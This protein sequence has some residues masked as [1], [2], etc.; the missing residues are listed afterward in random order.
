MKACSIV[1]CICRRGWAADSLDELLNRFHRWARELGLAGAT[2]RLF[3]DRWRS[4][5]RRN[6][7]IWR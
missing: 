7:P 4:A 2:V 5:R 3:P 1:C 6:L